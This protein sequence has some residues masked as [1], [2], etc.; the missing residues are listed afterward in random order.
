[1]ASQKDS[2][3]GCQPGRWVNSRRACSIIG[4]GGWNIGTVKDK[5]EAIAIMHEAIDNGLTFFDNC[6]DYH[7]GGSEEIMGK[8]LAAAGKRD[9]VFLMTKVCR[10]LRAPSSTSTTACAA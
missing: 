3:A 10:E 1:M 9:K 5:Q 4:L 7:H 2:P 8:A 6:W